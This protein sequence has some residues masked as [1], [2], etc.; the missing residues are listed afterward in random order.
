MKKL[1]L[2]SAACA[3]LALP[4][5]PKL[6]LAADDVVPI[7]GGTWVPGIYKCTDINGNRGILYFV[8]WL[9]PRC[10]MGG[11]K[12]KGYIPIATAVPDYFAPPVCDKFEGSAYNVCVNQE[13]EKHQQ[14]PPV[15]EQPPE[16]LPKQPEPK[17]QRVRFRP[18]QQIW[19]CNDIRITVT[20]PSPGVVNYDIGGTIWGGI[21]FTAVYSIG[22][23]GGLFLRGVPCARLR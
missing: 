2:A 20:N 7:P 8:T 11:G 15:A 18:T 5:Y 21:N 1:L 13:W 10:G 12:P 4:W 17:P 19:Q 6:L 16:E 22:P 23:D 14:E 3:I 9:E